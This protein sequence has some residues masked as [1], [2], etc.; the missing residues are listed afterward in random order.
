MR[1]ADLCEV[2]LL[3]LHIY[4]KAAQLGIKQISGNHGIVP[5]PVAFQHHAFCPLEIVKVFT[6]GG[7]YYQ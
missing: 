2:S 7:D 5:S 3:D 4:T 1:V 6:I